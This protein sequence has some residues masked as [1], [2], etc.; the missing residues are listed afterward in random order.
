MLDAAVEPRFPLPFCY[1]FGV[2]IGANL[3]VEVY[4]FAHFRL[5]RRLTTSVT[6]G[7]ILTF[8]SACGSAD[9]WQ[10]RYQRADR[11]MLSMCTPSTVA[12]S[13]P[14]QLTVCVARDQA[15]ALEL[16]FRA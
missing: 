10:G 2:S 6:V 7:V 13:V 14:A 12:R 1:S 9:I 16:W 3:R 15:D 4:V 5:S 8:V 11:C